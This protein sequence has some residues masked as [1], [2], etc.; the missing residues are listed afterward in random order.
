[1]IHAPRAIGEGNDDFISNYFKTLLAFCGFARNPS[2]TE[3]NT[4]KPEQTPSEI[5]SNPGRVGK[6]K[7]N[8]EIPGNEQEMKS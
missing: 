1:M 2:K 7:Q 4:S 5:E 8:L 3:E 6:S